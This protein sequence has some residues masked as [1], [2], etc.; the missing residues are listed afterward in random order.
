MF[1]ASACGSVRKVIEERVRIEG[2]IVHPR[3]C[4]GDDLM[5][6]G[7]NFRTIVVSG[8]SVED[9][10]EVTSGLFEIRLLKI[11]NLYGRVDQAVVILRGVY[12]VS[13]LHRSRDVPVARDVA[14]ANGC[15]RVSSINWI[16]ENLGEI[17]KSVMRVDLRAKRTW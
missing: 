13:K 4:R 6:R 10:A 17:Q 3:S 14:E 15:G 7:D 11:A 5:Q 12:A 2:T 9:H 16:D 8:I 1:H